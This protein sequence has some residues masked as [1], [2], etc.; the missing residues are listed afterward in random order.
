MFS[1]QQAADKEQTIALSRTD[2]RAARR[3]LR[4][5]LGLESTSAADIEFDTKTVPAEDTSRAA[6][7]GRAREDLANRR[8]R[9]ELFDCNMFG[10]A[11]WDML[12]SLYILDVS[13]QRQTLG[14]LVKFSR[15][16]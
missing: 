10:E 14:S 8:R 15:A 2:I 11:A 1:D 16:S 7:V 6:L 9:L 12:L 13:G 5:L 4:L 3:L